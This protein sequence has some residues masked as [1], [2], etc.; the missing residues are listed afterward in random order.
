MKDLKDAFNDIRRAREEME[1]LNNRLPNIIGRESLAVI[2]QNFVNE[3]YDDGVSKEPWKPREAATNKEYDRGRAM[4]KNGKLSKYRVGANKNYKASVFSSENKILEQTGTLRNSIRFKVSGKTVFIGVNLLR[5][6]YA[7]IHNEGLR[8]M[9][10]G[11]VPFR[12]PRRQFMPWP[13][14]GPNPKMLKR[15][16]RKLKFEQDRI[17]KIFKIA[18]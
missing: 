14:E 11:K 1:R 3:S 4:M 13:S 5:V 9:M 7:R 18:R 15:A 10:Y 8:G 12:M 2:D 16:A 6:P 17:M